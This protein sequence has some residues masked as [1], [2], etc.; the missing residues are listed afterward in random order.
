MGF[1]GVNDNSEVIFSYSEYRYPVRWILFFI[2]DL[3][4]LTKSNLMADTN[5]VPRERVWHPRRVWAHAGRGREGGM[6]SYLVL[7]LRGHQ[8]TVMVS[9]SCWRICSHQSVQRVPHSTTWGLR[10]WVA[11]LWSSLGTLPQALGKLPWAKRT[12]SPR[13]VPSQ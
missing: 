9:H 4:E 1:T 11:L 2:S 8:A 13:S 12:P 7:Q 6:E 3:D 5:C 10:N